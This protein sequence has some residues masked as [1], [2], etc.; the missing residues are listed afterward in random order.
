MGT[1]AGRIGVEGP[2]SES[3]TAAQKAGVVRGP[4]IDVTSV[5]D[6]VD[7]HLI[8]KITDLWP[9]PANPEEEDDLTEALR[10]H[11]RVAITEVLMGHKIRVVAP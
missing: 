8:A 10:S 7:H 3:S 9:R 4:S 1:V 5:D 6:A 2:R 11:L